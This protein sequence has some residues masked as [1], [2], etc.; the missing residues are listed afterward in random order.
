MSIPIQQKDRLETTPT[1]FQKDYPL[2][3]FCI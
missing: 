2:K 3:Y 1:S